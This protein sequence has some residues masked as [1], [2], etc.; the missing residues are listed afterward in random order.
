M[1]EMNIT[2]EDCA[3]VFTLTEEQLSYYT[4]TGYTLPTRCDACD[5][6]RRTKKAIEKAAQRPKRRRRRY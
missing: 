5:E 2:C 6:A 1:P 4:E 3:Q